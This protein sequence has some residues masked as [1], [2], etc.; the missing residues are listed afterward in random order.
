MNHSVYIYLNFPLRFRCWRSIEWKWLNRVN[1]MKNRN[2]EPE[3]CLR[4]RI[5]ALVTTKVANWHLPRRLLVA[6]RAD[7]C[8]AALARSIKTWLIIRWARNKIQ[9]EAAHSYLENRKEHERNES[10]RRKKRNA[11]ANVDWR[12]DFALSRPSAD[13]LRHGINISR[14]SVC[15]GEKQQHQRTRKQSWCAPAKDTRSALSNTSLINSSLFC[16]VSR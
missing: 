6:K 1:R 9:L 2:R 15:W 13:W 5:V 16:I 12:G 14:Q 10:E 4:D 3:L 8:P 7:L 11:N